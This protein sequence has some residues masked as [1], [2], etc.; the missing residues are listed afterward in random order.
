MERDKYE[1]ETTKL[2]RVLDAYGMDVYHRAI[3]PMP[4]GL[5][6]G[7]YF[8]PGGHGSLTPQFPKRGIMILGQDWGTVKNHLEAQRRIGPVD[9]DPT[10]DNMLALFSRAGIDATR[11]FFTNA[12]MGL[13]DRKKNT[14]KNPG[15]SHAPYVQFCAEVFFEQL[16]RQQPALVISLGTYVPQ[17]LSQLSGELAPWSA[18]DFA[19]RDVHG[20]LVNRATFKNKKLLAGQHTCA[21]ASIL[22]PSERNRNLWRRK[23]GRLVGDAAEVAVLS[24]A[25][26]VA[27]P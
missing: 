10:W 20:A 17:F 27:F 2:R 7:R 24:D 8:F 19:A 18:G 1:A 25:W 11:C 15:A 26:A 5:I 9:A 21:V 12:Y 3:K 16:N 23:Y 6:E 4:P 13:R 14:G 22:H